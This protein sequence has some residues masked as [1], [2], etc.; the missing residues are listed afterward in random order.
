MAE[1]HQAHLIVKISAPHAVP[2]AGLASKHQFVLSQLPE[3]V[4]VQDWV[5][6]MADQAG[7]G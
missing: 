7:R 2:W 4:C 6:C 5:R 1:G 3:L